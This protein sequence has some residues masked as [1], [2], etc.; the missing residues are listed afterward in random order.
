MGL[1][2]VDIDGTV[3]KRN[4]EDPNVRHPFDWK[5]VGEDLPN[6]PVIEVVR[7]LDSAGHTIFY[8]SG[9]SSVCY[10]ETSEWLDLYVGPIGELLL[11]RQDGD[12]RPDTVVKRELYEEKVFPFYGKPLAVLDDRNSVVKM[13]REELG[14]TV[15]QVA[16][17]DF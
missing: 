8:L 9:R 5:R 3:A 14:L 4:E 10:R 17:G 12:H 7:A 13:W 2:L 11:M 15:L 1:F 16:E 6:D